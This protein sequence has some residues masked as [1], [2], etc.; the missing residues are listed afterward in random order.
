MISFLEVPSSKSS[1]KLYELGISIE[2]GK[3]QVFNILFNFI[4]Y[5]LISF[6]VQK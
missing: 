6:F 4:I 3:K 5:Y 2:L 1:T